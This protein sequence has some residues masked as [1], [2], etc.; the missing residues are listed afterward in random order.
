MKQLITIL[1]VV[2]LVI[3]QTGTASHRN[4]GGCYESRSMC[5]DIEDLGSREIDE[6]P[7]PIILDSSSKE[8]RD[9]WGEA[10]SSGNTHE[11]TDIF[12]PTGSLIV[13]PTDGVVD[14]TGVSGLGGKHVFVYIGG[15]EKLYF[16]HLDDWAEDLEEGRELQKGDLVGYVGNTGAEWALPHLHLAIYENGVAENPY[17][18]MKGEDW[19]LEEKMESLDLV[20]RNEDNDDLVEDIYRDYRTL[21]DEAIQEDIDLPRAIAHMMEEL[22]EEAEEMAETALTELAEQIEDHQEAAV[23][24]SDLEEA[25]KFST[26]NDDLSISKGD[27]DEIKRLQKFLNDVEDARVEENG[28]FDGETLEAVKAFQ[29]KYAQE[30]LDIWGLDQATGYVGITTRLKINF[31]INASEQTQCPVF[32][33]YNSRTQN[34]NSDEVKQTEELLQD[35]GFFSD[36]PDRTWDT[37]THRA[38]IAFQERFSAT[39]LTPWGLSS[40]TGYKYKTTNKFMNYL[41]GCDTPPV[42]LEG[43]GEF[44]F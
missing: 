32:T 44:D 34:T 24:G 29:E 26:F 43:R 8:L 31:L 15:G 14:R 38:M 2:F 9:T 22:E 6:F 42:T 16:A 28:V 17:P 10:R 35:L 18:R 13:M 21:F 5:D 1:T 40:G 19:D 30:V 12:A 20:F 7:N 11:G 36:N 33:E 39:M 27:P 41:V 3:P 23:R 37:N 25:S 4:S